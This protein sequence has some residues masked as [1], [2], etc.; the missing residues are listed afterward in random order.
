MNLSCKQMFSVAPANESVHARL[1]LREFVSIGSA[2]RA[3]RRSLPK[4]WIAALMLLP[5]LTRPGAGSAP[6]SPQIQNGFQLMYDLKFAQA[7]QEFG[8]FEQRYRD[9]PM[10]PASEAAGL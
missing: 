2:I 10:G 9:N 3:S 5:L 6:P 8:A 4:V 7:E 1:L